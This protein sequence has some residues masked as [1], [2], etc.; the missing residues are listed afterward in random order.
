MFKRILACL[1]VFMTLV[2]YLPP[3]ASAAETQPQIKNDVTVEGTNSFGTLLANTVQNDPQS[4]SE[5]ENSRICDLQIEG[6]LATVEY[7]TDR[8]AKVVVAI[9]T[10]DGATM[11]GSGVTEVV[12]EDTQTVVE[13]Q[14]ASMPQYYSAAA[15]LLDAE[16]NDPLSQVFRT[17]LYTKVVQDVKNS[18]VEDYDPERVLNLDNSNTTNFAVFGENTILVQE[19]S[20]CQISGGNGVYTV[21]NADERFLSMKAGDSFA[22]PQSDGS[23]LIVKAAKV[24]VQGDT[25]TIYEDANADLSDVFEVIKI[26]ATADKKDTTY[27]DST[28]DPDF[29][30]ISAEEFRARQGKVAPYYILDR[31]D[32]ASFE[33]EFETDGEN[34]QGSLKLKGTFELK[35]YIVKTH[36][37]KYAYV[38]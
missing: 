7:T 17:Q 22:A 32:E 16:T 6:T 28:L 27:D 11:L 1:L 5:G 10:E 29:K 26:E 18:T 30:S 15:Y 33:R 24:S 12:P 9:Y 8:A 14:I 37:N 20:P 3:K 38:S 35:V 31:E 4:Q 19:G 25:V 13:I 2:S 34:L 23:T 36:A 21:T